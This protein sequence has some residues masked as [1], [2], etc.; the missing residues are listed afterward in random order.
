MGNL[1]RLPEQFCEVLKYF[2]I[3]PR[4][5]EPY[6]MVYRIEAEEGFFALKE[7][8]YPEDEF[9]YIYAATEH[10]AAQGF[11]RINRMILSQKFYPFVE[12]NGKRYF[13]S[14]WIIGREANYHQ[15]SD[16][17]IAARTLA[18]LHKSS[19]GFEPPYF[20]GRI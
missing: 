7:I 16:L 14:R 13:L 15:K 6:K 4:K 5:V 3:S 19:K 11:D 9:C 1:Y 18:E 20:E 17:K 12:Y 10:L 8:K 2:P